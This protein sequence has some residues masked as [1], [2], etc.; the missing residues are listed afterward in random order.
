MVIFA[1]KIKL[2]STHEKN[3]FPLSSFHFLFSLL[4]LSSSFL[5][6]SVS[7][8]LSL[9]CCVSFLSPFSPPS[10]SPLP[11]SLLTSLTASPSHCLFS[12]SYLSSSPSSPPSFSPSS[13]PSPPPLSSPLLPPPPH[14]FLLSPL[15]LLLLFSFWKY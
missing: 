7:Y 11:P 6:P 14:L 4:F 15:P 1:A 12:F 2:V 3:S 13:S 10:L 8:S 9:F 5:P